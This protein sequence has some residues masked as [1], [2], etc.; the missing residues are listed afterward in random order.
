MKFH[1]TGRLFVQSHNP[2]EFGGL[3]GP[4]LPERG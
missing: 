1:G 3:L 2:S 4:L